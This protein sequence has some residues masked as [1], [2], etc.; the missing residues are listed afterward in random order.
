MQKKPK[1][2]QKQKTGKGKPFP[3]ELTNMAKISLRKFLDR[4][5]IELYENINILRDSIEKE[6]IENGEQILEAM[7]AELNSL[8]AIDKICEDRNRY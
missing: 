7:Y 4:R 6:N 1:R 2:Q 3:P 5:R 8:K